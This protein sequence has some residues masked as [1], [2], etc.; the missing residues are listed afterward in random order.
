MQKK[1]KKIH[2]NYPYNIRPSPDSRYKTHWDT[3]DGFWV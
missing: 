2:P 3:R 1:T